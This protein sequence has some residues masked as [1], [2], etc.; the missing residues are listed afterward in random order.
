[1]APN[2][3]QQL[4][5]GLCPSV[6]TYFRTL[7][8]GAVVFPSGPSLQSRYDG[9]DVAI[10]AP[11]DRR[12]RA[13]VRCGEE[14]LTFRQSRHVPGASIFEREDR[15]SS[16]AT[17]VLRREKSFRLYTVMAAIA[18]PGRPAGLHLFALSLPKYDGVVFQFSD[19]AGLREPDFVPFPQADVSRITIESDLWRGHTL[20]CP[21]TR[22][23][24]LAPL[25]S[26][27]GLEGATHVDLQGY[28][29][30]SLRAAARGLSLIFRR[31][32][33]ILFELPRRDAFGL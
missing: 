9:Y 11:P 28:F 6:A 25:L 5:T 12:L 22:D 3:F 4:S 21:L 8:H 27:A 33:E 31:G 13:T 1:M 17:A 16:L 26:A 30:D 32:S 10:D 20:V 23:A 24:E 15:D 14:S 19:E 18:A 2:L 29:V 7:T